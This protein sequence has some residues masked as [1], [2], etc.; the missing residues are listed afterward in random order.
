[1]RAKEVV[2]SFIN[3]GKQTKFFIFMTALYMIAIAWTTVQAYARLEYSRS[4]YSKPILILAA[5]VV[6][7]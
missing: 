2:S 7:R 3:S 1:M 6:V 4:D 5:S